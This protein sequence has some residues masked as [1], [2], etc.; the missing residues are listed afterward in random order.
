[1]LL[2]LSPFAILFAPTAFTD[3][4]LTLFLSWLRRGRRWHDGPGWAGVLLGL[5]CASKQQGVMGVPLVL[6]LVIV[7]SVG[8]SAKARRCAK[9]ARKREQRV[10]RFG[11]A[12]AWGSR[13]CFGAVTYW[14]SLRW[15]NRPSYWDQ[16][17]QTYGG[18]VLAPLGRVARA[19]CRVGA[20]RRA[21]GSA[22]GR[23]PLR[24]SA[25]SLGWRSAIR[26]ERAPSQ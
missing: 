17:L 21:T 19:G 12:D 5:A 7:G 15:H 3:G 24:C 23:L 8:W 9:R 20:T 22:P 6:A 1:M 25:G 16:S 18:V 10:G 11:L 13:S 26:E 4:W 2:A 14:D